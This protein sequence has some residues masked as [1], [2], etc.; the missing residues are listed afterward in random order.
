MYV[1][2]S[3][4]PPPSSGEF[5]NTRGS[6]SSPSFV[7]MKLYLSEKKIIIDFCLYAGRRIEANHLILQI[8]KWEFIK[9]QIESMLIVL[10][11]EYV[12]LV[13]G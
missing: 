11:K 1:I 7:L 2:N 12:K 8:K 5:D 13:D 9:N 6:V 3:D 4:Q 10:N